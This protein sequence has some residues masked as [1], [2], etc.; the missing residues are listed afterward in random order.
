MKIVLRGTPPSM[1]K[2]LGRKN[3]WEWRGVKKNWT[4]KVYLACQPSPPKAYESA[5]VRIDYFFKTRLRRD[6]DNFSGKMLLDGLTRAGVIVD[7]DF[8][9]IALAVHGHVDP[10]DPRTEITVVPMEVDVNG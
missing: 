10:D 4:E 9:H 2:F 8:G 5:L 3:E 1:N 7:D 6:P